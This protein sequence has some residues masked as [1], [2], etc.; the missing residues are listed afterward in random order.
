MLIKIDNSYLTIGFSLEIFY[1]KHHN[2]YPINFKVL[3]DNSLT[4]YLMN[5][6]FNYLTL[7]KEKYYKLKPT[8]IEKD[9][10]LFHYIEDTIIC[11]IEDKNLYFNILDNKLILTNL[12]SSKVEIEFNIFDR[13]ILGQGEYG[14]VYK[15]IPC[16]NDDI[17]PINEV[18]KVFKYGNNYA[19]DAKDVISLFRDNIEIAEKYMIL[20]KKIC[21]IK[22]IPTDVNFGELSTYQVIYDLVDTKIREE[23]I[24]NFLI[25]DLYRIFTPFTNI[26]HA[27]FFLGEN[28]L[29]N[30]D[31]RLDN[32][33]KDFNSGN[34]MMIDMMFNDLK[35]LD[36]FGYTK[37]P[38]TLLFLVGDLNNKSLQEEENNQLFLRNTSLQERE[39]NQLSL[40]NTSLQ[41]RENDFKKEKERYILRNIGEQLKELFSYLKSV[42]YELYD[43]LINNVINFNETN[44]NIY[45]NVNLSNSDKFT[46]LNLYSFTLCILYR[47]IFETDIK[48]NHLQ[49]NLLRKFA[50]ACILHQRKYTKQEILNLWNNFLVSLP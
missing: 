47:L 27:C 19:K 18:S 28:E 31:L 21:V 32:I 7:Y 5:K 36:I 48:L 42:D 15:R 23:T 8:R 11:K 20:P 37:Q 46:M 34:Y 50:E 49:L 6:E 1:E 29:F 39:N 33:G 30:I 25:N 35:N 38:F 43:I 14:I 44:F 3:E 26:I 41:E 17:T 22:N 16:E 45:S 9:S 2:F 12:K 10:I 13:D 24:K 40:R 4:F